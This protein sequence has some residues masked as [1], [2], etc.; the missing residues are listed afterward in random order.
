M[1]IIPLRLILL[2]RER[3]T[4]SSIQRTRRRLN[5]VQARLQ[6]VEREKQHLLHRWSLLDSSLRKQQEQE[7]E[8]QLPL[9]PSLRTLDNYLEAREQQKVQQ[10]ESLLLFQ[11]LGAEHRVPTPTSPHFLIPPQSNS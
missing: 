9:P 8:R 1:R 5:R 6:K 3:S 10:Q 7:Q 4:R 11:T 2:F